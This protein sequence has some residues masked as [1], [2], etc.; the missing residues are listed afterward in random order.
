MV[1]QR[2]YKVGTSWG[3]LLAGAIGIGSIVGAYTFVYYFA[4][5]GSSQPGPVLADSVIGDQRPTWSPDG[6]RVAISSGE[7]GDYDIYVQNADGSE[8]NRITDS[9]ANETH[10]VWA[11]NG[12]RIAYISRAADSSSDIP[13]ELQLGSSDIHVVNSDGSGRTNLTNFPSLYRDLVWSPDG[14]KIAFVSNRDI[15]PAGI[16]I[17]TS[18]TGPP[19]RLKRRR[20]DIYVMNA[21]GSDQTRLTF[22]LASDTKPAWSPDSNNIAFQSNRDGNSEIYIV[23]VDSGG[24]TRLTENEVTDVDPVWSPD[25]TRIAFATA[26]IQTEFQRELQEGRSAQPFANV[27]SASFSALATGLNFDIYVVN[28]DGTGAIN[29]SNSPSSDDTRPVWSPDGDYV[30]FDGAH[31]PAQPGVPGDT[32]VYVVKLEGAGGVL[33]ITGTS[34]AKFKAPTHAG[35]AWSPD[36]RLIGYMSKDEDTVR[37]QVVQLVEP[38]P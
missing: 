4:I 14:T 18:E 31:L 22:D 20:P 37:V 1:F 36:G 3:Y 6:T 33:P 25:G 2:E 19:A 10:P 26:R 35:P 13:P 28:A 12:E 30:A 34:L 16:G 23:D 15:R 38:T 32:E 21:D 8:R 5:K 11:P 24:L 7:T 27:G 29:L 17:P 9:L